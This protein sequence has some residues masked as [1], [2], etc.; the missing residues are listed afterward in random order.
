M[1][2]M[3]YK[4]LVRFR[5]PFRP[6]DEVTRDM[7]ATFEEARAEARARGWISYAGF[8]MR[9]LT[10]LVLASR[11]VKRRWPAVAAWGLGGLAVG[12]A[13]T[14]IHPPQY[15]SE[16]FLRLSPPAIAES[17][18]PSDPSLSVDNV[19]STVRPIVLSRT[20]L[21]SVIQAFGLYQ[22]ERARQPIEAVIARMRQNIR[23]ERQGEN[24][25]LVAF[26]YGDSPWG[27]LDQYLP[28]DLVPHDRPDRY[29][30]Q[31]VAQDLLSRLIDQTVRER[32]NQAFMAQRF[33]EDRSEDAATRWEKLNAAMQGLVPTDRRYERAVLDRD[34]ARKEYESLRQKYSD[35]EG[36]ALLTA[37]MQSRNLELLDPASLPQVPDTEPLWIVLGGLAAGLLI[38]LLSAWLRTTREKPARLLPGLVEG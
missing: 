11:P 30:A 37:R 25:I 19:L 14:Y 35:S 21:A 23:I 3:L 7:L 5:R 26:T 28:G 18:Y 20:V 16:A 36:M 9:E 34:L 22:S 1:L 27:S 4:L 2:T 6:M 8:A 32:R 24:V 29:L 10:G 33:F 13:I 12:V 17:L 38:G 31:R 15:S